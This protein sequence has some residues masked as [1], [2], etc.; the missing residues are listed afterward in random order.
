MA[1]RRRL[2]LVCA[3]STAALSWA[4][5]AQAGYGIQ[6]AAGSTT[7]SQ[8]T[9]L[10]YLDSQDSNP[11]VYVS[12]SPSMDSVGTPAD[13]AGLCSPTT[14]FGEAN[15]YTCQPSDYFTTS[16]SSL[17][18]GTY[19]WWMSFWRT[20]PDHP[21]GA[22]E[23][24][25]PFQFTV[26][27]PV[28]PADTYLESPADGATVSTSPQVT[29]HAPAGAQ[30]QFYL[31]DS[32][33]RLDDDSPAGTTIKSCTGTAPNSSDY[34]C[35]AAAGTLRDGKTYYWWVIVTVDGSGWIY[36]PRSFNYAAS[37]NGGGGG[38]GGGSGIQPHNLLFAPHLRSL[39]HFT[40]LVSIKQNRLT[41]AAYALSKALGHPKSIDVA[42][43]DSLD[44]ENISGDNPESTYSTLGL[45]TDLLPHWVN[46]SPSICHTFETLIYH[47]PEY[48]NVF[49]A[50]ALDTLTHEMIHALGIHN[51]AMTECFAMQ[52]SFATG[53]KMGLPLQYAEN[54]DRL[55]LHNYLRHPANYVDTLRC[56]ED[57]AWDLDKGEPSLPWHLLSL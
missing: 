4:G 49:T 34:Y 17:S 5:V 57:G 2:L 28:A 43:W 20:D 42:C 19:Y 41:Q 38:G 39:A 16:T 23:I 55:S 54:L 51:E 47:R 13:E 6:P 33:V 44:W 50:N 30:L 37:G 45:W 52:L 22:E 11:E 7:G 48:A 53:W 9:F 29:V 14:P 27:A 1:L 31:S 12:T 24:S 26:A 32:D 25:G 10:V 56:R 46:L 40:G 21:Y 15:K 35:Q 18:P 3:V 8:P 36:G